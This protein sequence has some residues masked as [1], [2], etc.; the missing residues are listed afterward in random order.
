M[1]HVATSSKLVRFY[2]LDRHK[3]GHNLFKVLI[4]TTTLHLSL[5]SVSQTSSSHDNVAATRDLM[6]TLV[7]AEETMLGS[8]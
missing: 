1:F 2:L 3:F 6:D 8:I 7:S 5:F 4:L